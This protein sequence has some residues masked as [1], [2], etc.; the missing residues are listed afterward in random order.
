MMP[1]LAISISAL[2]LLELTNAISIPEKNAEHRSAM[3]A[4]SNGD[5]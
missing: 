2:T 5:V 4:I 1:P 3:S